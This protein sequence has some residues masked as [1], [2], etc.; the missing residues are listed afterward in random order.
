MRTLVVK[1]IG[2]WGRRQPAGTEPTPP[3]ALHVRAEV[4]F[5]GLEVAGM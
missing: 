3:S 5:A 1:S 4:L 2:W